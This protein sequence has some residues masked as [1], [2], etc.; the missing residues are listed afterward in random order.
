MSDPE[1]ELRRQFTEVFGQAEYPLTDPFDLIPHLP[2]GAETE[3]RAGDVVVPAIDLGLAYGEYQEY[4]YAS[5]DALVE[6]LIAA[7]EAEDVL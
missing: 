4:P 5:V 3:F 1:A 2:D 7:L 6:D